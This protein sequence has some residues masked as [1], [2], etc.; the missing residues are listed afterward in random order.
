MNKYKLI[1]FDIDGTLLPF[2]AKNFSEKIKKMFFSLKE[3]NY[4]IV[5]ATGREFVTIGNLMDGLPIDYFIGANGVFIY[6]VNQSKTIFENK[7]ILND[8]LKLSKFLENHNKEY[9]VMSDKWG[10]FSEG[11]YLDT[12]FLEP[13]KKYFK[14][15]SELTSK[16]EPLHLITV[17]TEDKDFYQLTKKFIENN[18]LNL[19]INA[20][21]SKGFFIGPLNTNKA[22]ALKKLHDFTNVKLNE[23]IAFG[24]SS[25]DVEMLSEVG[26]SVALSN[27]SEYL[28]K[29][30]NDV[31]TK[32]VDEDGVYHKLIELGII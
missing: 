25:N 6:D 24:D 31:T 11:H 10:Y 29:I 28:K 7:I 17:K 5:L 1:A 3:K 12:W 18:K 20:T 21:W 30:A 32:S 16:D 26:Y 23:I 2:A 15:L 13:H 22:T 4:I 19:E 9:S 27:G 14:S 8:F